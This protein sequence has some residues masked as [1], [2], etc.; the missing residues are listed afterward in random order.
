MLALSRLDLLPEKSLMALR[1]RVGVIQACPG[2]QSGRDA[3]A[4]FL[5]ALRLCPSRGKG[6]G[7]CLLEQ[8]DSVEKDFELLCTQWVEALLINL[9]TPEA[10]K[11]SLLKP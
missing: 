5:P 11:S 2:L 6:Q 3:H 9:D 1:E 10:R 8:L 7:Y 4:R